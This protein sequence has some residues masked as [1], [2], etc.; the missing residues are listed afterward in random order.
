MATGGARRGAGRP[1]KSTSVVLVN[2]KAALAPL[3]KARLTERLMDK[4]MGMNITPLEVMLNTMKLA[5]DQGQLALNAREREV[6][7]DKREYMLRI[8]QAQMGQASLVAEKVAGYLHPKLQA[9][10]LK[11]DEK[12]PLEMGV[13]FRN[14]SDNDLKTMESIMSKVNG[15][16]LKTN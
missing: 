1:K 6:D 12:N 4:V 7:N 10:T 2:A 13:N 5:Y 8:A 15:D 14:L 9:V 3:A 11:G 16:D